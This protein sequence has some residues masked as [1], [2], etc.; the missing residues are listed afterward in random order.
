MN[1]MQQ[2]YEKTLETVR[3]QFHLARELNEDA[4]IEWYQ[5]VKKLLQAE[6]DDADVPLFDDFEF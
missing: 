5:E 6:M 2:Q 3:T 4:R 1:P